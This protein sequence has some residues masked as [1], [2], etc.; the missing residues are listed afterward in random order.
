MTTWP[1]FTEAMYFPGDLK[2][3]NGQ[4]ALLRFIERGALHM[5]IP[6]DSETRRM[7]VLMEKY[8]DTLQN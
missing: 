7:R 2:G 4:D 5:H 3:W 1:C 6:T 8:R